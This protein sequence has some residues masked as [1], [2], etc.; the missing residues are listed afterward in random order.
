MLCRDVGKSLGHSL[1]GVEIVAVALGHKT[2]LS[3]GL[4]GDKKIQAV[5]WYMMGM[6]FVLDGVVAKKVTGT[7]QKNWLWDNVLKAKLSIVIPTV[8]WVEKL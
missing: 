6:S 5:D 1:L 2:Q 4:A 7:V 3:A 8:F